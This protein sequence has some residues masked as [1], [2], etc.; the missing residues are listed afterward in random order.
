MTSNDDNSSGTTGGFALRFL[1][2]LFLR[3]LNNNKFTSSSVTKPPVTP[4]KIT[5]RRGK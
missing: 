3:N 4:E 2:S 5:Q 1:R